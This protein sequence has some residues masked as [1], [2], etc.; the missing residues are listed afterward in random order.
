MPKKKSVV[1]AA[2]VAALAGAMGLAVAQ[3]AMASGPSMNIVEGPGVP[4]PPATGGYAGAAAAVAQCPAGQFLT[5]GGANVTA[6]T[7]YVQRYNLAASLPISGQRWWAYATNTDPTIPG[8]LTAYAICAT[9]TSINVVQTPLSQ[10]TGR[11]ARAA[12]RSPARSLYAAIS[13]P[14]SISV[15]TSPAGMY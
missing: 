14:M 3:P 5:G 4:I 6:G 13:C 11:R 7:S 8:T 15:W 12:A 10:P 9:A 1:S 2:L